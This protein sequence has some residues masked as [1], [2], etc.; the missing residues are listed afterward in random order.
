MKLRPTKF[1][2]VLAQ[3]TLSAAIAL[4]GVWILVSM[5]DAEAVL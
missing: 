4:T 1:T 3:A 5:L 2:R